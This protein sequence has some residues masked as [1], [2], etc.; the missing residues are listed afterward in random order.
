MH[1]VEKLRGEPDFS[2]PPNDGYQSG[3]A[4][5]ARREYA[6]HFGSE[7]GSDYGHMFLKLAR[8]PFSEIQ[9]TRFFDLPDNHAMLDI[10]LG[11]AD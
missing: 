10:N 11:R 7:P 9:R 8:T 1:G 4:S 2:R 3:L 6:S 5:I